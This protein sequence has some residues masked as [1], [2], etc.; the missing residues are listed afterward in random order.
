[1]TARRRKPR[2]GEWCEVHWR[3]AISIATWVDVENIQ[4][5]ARVPD[6]KSRGCLIVDNARQ[7][8]LASTFGH[9]LLGE[10]LGIPKGMIIKITRIAEPK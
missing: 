1:M 6:M 2:P 7:I 10:V 9:E 3:D 5:E 8:I 4:E